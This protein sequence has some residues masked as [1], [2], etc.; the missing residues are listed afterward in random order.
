M[1][2]NLTIDYEEFTVISS[3]WH[4]EIKKRSKRKPVK[5]KG[6]NKKLNEKKLVSIKYDKVVRMRLVN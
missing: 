2:M 5:T 6:K 3:W 4:T 1:R